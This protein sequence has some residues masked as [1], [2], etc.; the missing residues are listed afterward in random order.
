MLNP[1]LYGLL[2]NRFRHVHVCNEGEELVGSYKT[3]PVSGR[4]V[5]DIEA[6]GETYCVN[7]PYC[8]DTRQR[9]Y[10]SHRY[11]VHDLV[12]D[13]YN[14]R[15]VRC[16]NEEC[17]KKDTSLYKHLYDS[18]FGLLN[19]AQRARLSYG[20]G[21]K[22]VANSTELKEGPPPGLLTYIQDLPPNHPALAYLLGERGYSLK[23]LVD[24][25]RLM[26]CEAASP[27]YKLAEHRIIIPIIMN[28]MWVG[29]QA[30]FVGEANF[31]QLRIPKYFTLPSMPKR[32]VLYNHDV[33]LKQDTVVV[34]EGPTSAWAVGRCA[35]AL[36]GKQATIQQLRL[37]S[38]AYASK[39]V[40][41]LLDGDATADA[42]RLQKQLQ[43]HVKNLVRVEL[44]P[45]RDPGSYYHERSKLW[46]LIKEQAEGQGITLPVP[47]IEAYNAEA[48]EEC[49]SCN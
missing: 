19:P 18:V 22:P 29:W 4:M 30:R 44:P 26:Y 28:G 21:K 49:R 42:I 45:D 13:S 41:I 7:C 2:K 9:L 27:E 12:T 8:N 36:L 38:T 40:V 37:L 10:I 6:R 23:E 48:E 11:G 15:M 39:N 32:L 3:D 34:C 24:D 17:L 47:E 20:R 1:T 31:K 43:K 16:F 25:W 35:I 5:L 33:A 14:T 46:T